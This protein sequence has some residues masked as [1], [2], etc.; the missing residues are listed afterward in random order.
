MPNAAGRLLISV[1]ELTKSPRFLTSLALSEETAT[2]VRT[3]NAGFG[4]IHPTWVLML[5]GDGDGHPCSLLPPL[6]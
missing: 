5:S 2:A 4:S 6:Y 1:L 3:E